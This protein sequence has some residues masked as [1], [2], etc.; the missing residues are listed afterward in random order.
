MSGSKLK[1]RGD[2]A[3]TAKKCQAKMMETE[4]KIIERVKRG[5][6]WELEAQ[7]K[8]KERPEE[9]VMEE[10]EKFMTQEMAEDFLYLRRHC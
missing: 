7:I 4:V 5:K 10:L 9:E 1:S 2:I 3:A 8:D 6:R